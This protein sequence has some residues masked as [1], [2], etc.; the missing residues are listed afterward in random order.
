M[1]HTRKRQLFSLL[2]KRLAHFPVVGILGARQTGKSTLLRDIL[3][4]HRTTRYITLDR[5]EELREAERSPTLF[6]QNLESKS[7]RTVCIDEVQKAPRLFDTIKAEVDENRHPG[8]FAVSGSTDFS[9][10]AGIRESLTG[11][12]A[13]LRLFPLN[14][15]EI[16]GIES[17]Y[18][19]TNSDF[20]KPSAEPITLKSISQWFSRGGMPGIFASRDENVRHSLFD[21]WVETTCMRDLSRFKITRFNPDLARS[22]FMAICKLDVSNRTE[23]A[24]EVGRQ[25]RQIESYLDAM[26]AIYIINEVEPHRTGVGKPLFFP[27]DAGIASYLGA[28]EKK[29]KQIWFL[30]ELYSQ[31]SYAGEM[32]PNVFHYQTSRGSVLDFIIESRKSHYA[33]L[34]SDEEAPR[35]HSLAPA[36]AFLKSHPKI[37][38]FVLAP[39]LRLKEIVPKMQIVPWTWVA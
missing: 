38:V 30:N 21:A 6:L 12:I 32:R 31:F 11:R 22:L 4:E 17:K 29:S 2:N 15:A 25:P 33:I 10:K 1:P 23:I 3:P 36:R 26:K 13:M 35:P 28:T 37:P 16:A 34:L 18:P 20:K 7:I 14:Q 27:F 19:L 39:C 8:R 5:D 24:R 9:K